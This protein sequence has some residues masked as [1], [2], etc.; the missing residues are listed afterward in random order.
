MFLSSTLGFNHEIIQGLLVISDANI[1]RV[2]VLATCHLFDIV[3]QVIPT[4]L[5]RN[6]AVALIEEF[7]R[8]HGLGATRPMWHLAL[9]KKPALEAFRLVQL[10]SLIL[11]PHDL[12]NVYVTES[13]SLSRFR[14]ESLR[15]FDLF[16]WRVRALTDE[17]DLERAI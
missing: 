2:T 9:R 8:L 14:L 15:C 5:I 3:C 11:H 12:A 6:L 17:V 1:I 16:F 13:L 10:T 7:A 4:I